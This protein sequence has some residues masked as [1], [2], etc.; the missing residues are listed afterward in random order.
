MLL[1]VVGL[2]KALIVLD[3]YGLDE[4]CSIP[5]RSRDFF[6]PPPRAG[7]QWNPPTLLSSRYCGLFPRG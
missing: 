6:F 2:S 4:R 5:G 7:R 3:R 1:L